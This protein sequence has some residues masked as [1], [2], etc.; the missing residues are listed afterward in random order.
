MEL[1]TNEA[2]HQKGMNKEMV[3]IVVLQEYSCP[4]AEKME[5]GGGGEGYRTGSGTERERESRNRSS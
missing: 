4:L 1:A 5:R 2:T 3:A